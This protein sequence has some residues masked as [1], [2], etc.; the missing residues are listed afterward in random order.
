VG[1]ILPDPGIGAQGILDGVVGVAIDGD[2][3]ELRPGYL[4][5][6]QGSPGRIRYDNP[7]W[8]TARAGT[9]GRA[10]SAAGLRAAEEAF[11]DLTLDNLRID[12]LD[13]L[14]SY[15]IRIAV[16]GRGYSDSLQAEAPVATTVRVDHDSAILE[17]F[18]LWQLIE[19]VRALDFGSD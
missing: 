13:P 17:R 16:D 3:V 4:E 18:P 9:T 7:G 10:T 15:P 12:F 11:S 19:L 1:Q 6:R 2:S 5:L 8:L 14:Y